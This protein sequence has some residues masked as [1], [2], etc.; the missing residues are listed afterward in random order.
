MKTFLAPIATPLKEQFAASDRQLIERAYDAAEHAHSGQ[1]RKSGDAYITH[2]VAVAQ[3]LIDL[4]LDA[5]TI[6][7]ALLHDT[8][9]DTSYSL[10]TL[11]NEFGPRVADLV[12][13][14]TKLD[15]LS[16]GPTA[17]AETVRKMVVAM[18]RD[19]KSTRLNSS[20]SSVSRMPS[21]A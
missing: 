17:E 14:V 21:S 11:R 3:I 10:E 4:G 7:A 20:H 19:R 6:A 15:R 1:V 12:E 2:P 18:S 16:Y 13:G 8:V 5:E 9:E